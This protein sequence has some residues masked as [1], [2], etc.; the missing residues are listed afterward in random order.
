M[1]QFSRKTIL[2]AIDTLQGMS[3]SAITRYVLEYGLENVVP[4][5]FV[6][7]QER[8]T[9]LSKYLLKSPQRLDADGSNLTDVIVRERIASAISDCTSCYDGF[10]YEAFQ[11][12]YCALHRGLKRDGF[13][14]KD[15]QLRKTL[16]E[17]VGLPQ[18]D[19]EVHLLLK[20]YNFDTALGHLDQAIAAHAQGS[21]ASA[22][23][24]LRT[25]AEELF[26]K[27][28]ERLAGAATQLPPAGNE[29]RK[30][31]ADRAPPFFI[32]ELNEW[33]GNGTGFLEGFYRRLHPQGS[34]PGL[35]DEDDSTFR[36]HLVL[37]VARLLLNRL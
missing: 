32:G 27:M 33:K 1:P 15:G 31:L 14:V 9:S 17:D 23:A 11:S 12:N 20:S 19:D 10:D 28:A 30:W 36:L 4:E 6:N 16:P 37:L 3:H 25:F 13:T 8:A 29:R 18:T 22:N 26:D 35:S 5:G 7:K 34:H 2:A 24:Q 21:W